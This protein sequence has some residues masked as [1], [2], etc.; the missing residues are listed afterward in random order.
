MKKRYCHY[1][2]KFLFQRECQLMKIKDKIK[3]K[4]SKNLRN[5]IKNSKKF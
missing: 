4:Y 2:K 1:H 3:S 5:F